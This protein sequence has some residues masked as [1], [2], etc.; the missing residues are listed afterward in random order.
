MK[1]FLGFLA[2]LVMC[3]TLLVAC[4]HSSANNGEC[5]H[6]FSKWEVTKEASCAGAGA[7]SRSCNLC[8]YTQSEPI[9]ALSHV[10]TIDAAVAPTCTA[11]GLTEGKHCSVCNTVTLAQQAVA[12]L[13][14]TEVTDAAVA[15]TCTATG[16]TEGKHCAV[17]GA[18]TLAQQS[19]PVLE[20]SYGTPVSTAPT[21]AAAGSLVYSCSACGHSYSE[22]VPMPQ[23]SANEVYELAKNS[24]GEVITYDNNGNPLSQ[25]SCFAYRKDGVVVTNYHVIDGACSASV[26]LSGVTYEVTHVLAYDVDIDLA[27]LLIAGSNL[28]VLPICVQTH[29]VGKTVYA[30]GSPRGLTSTFSQGIITA[31]R[32]MNGVVYVQH[33]AS[34]TNGN[35]GGPLINEYG[36]IV[37]INTLVVRDS[38]NLNFAV[39]VSELSNLQ[40]GQAMTLREVYEKESNVFEKIKNYIISAGTYDAKNNSYRLHLGAYV[41]DDGY[42]YTRTANYY[43]NTNKIELWVDVN[44]IVVFALLIDAVDGAYEWA[45]LDGTMN[46]MKGSVNAGTFQYG[47]TLSFSETN[48]TDYATLNNV[49]Q[50]ASSLATTLCLFVNEDF[51]AIGVSAAALGFIHF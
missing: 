11:T 14:H 49:R 27:I 18:I 45:Y 26:F 2:A 25:G 36:E 9:A 28:K 34:I 46:Y 51:S 7:Q 42:V 21:C 16:L 47:Q 44:E 15:P 1:K 48:I 13:P 22:T 29:A 39:N 12:M 40:Y 23:Y 37:G 10:E 20:H 43:A 6:E 50:L 4:D 41:A 17:C 8:G 31:N 33:D 38:Q 19:I 35:S 3:A 5:V 32:E 24:V 30:F